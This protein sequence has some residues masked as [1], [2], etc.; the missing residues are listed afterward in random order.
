MLN[1]LL[2][3]SPEGYPFFLERE[4]DNKKYYYLKL[5]D[6]YFDQDNVKVLESLENGHIYSLIILKLYLKAIKHDGQLKMTEAIPYSPVQVN[7]LANVIHHDVDHVKEAIKAAIG[8]DILQVV[9]NKELWMTQIQNF[10]GHSSSEGDR[11]RVYRTKI[12]GTDVRLNDERTPELELKIK[13]E[14]KT[15]NKPSPAAQGS[16]MEFW[17]Y[18]LKVV[19]KK[20]T[21]N[22]IRRSLIKRRL[23][24]GF[25]VEQLKQAVDN[26]IKDT[27][28]GRAKH[29]D[30][31]YCIGQQKGGADNL[32][33]WLNIEPKE[34]KFEND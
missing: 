33:K 5:K 16:V 25:T 12:K 27:W 32:E 24:E 13:K 1:R 3:L 2:Y 19:D 30:L 9:D 20:F 31:I 18:Y 34:D 26:F 28:E 17:E 14:I 4:M 22:A 10:I 15:D 6:N 21:L 11:L 29:L 8:L 7:T 23:K